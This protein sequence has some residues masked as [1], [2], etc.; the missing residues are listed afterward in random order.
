MS[1]VQSTSF[2]RWPQVSLLV[3]WRKERY[4]SLIE[5]EIASAESLNSTDVGLML[6]THI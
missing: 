6:H 1:S 5:G 3:L 2:L 4:G